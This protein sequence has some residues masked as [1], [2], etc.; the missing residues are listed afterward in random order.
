MKTTAR[1]RPAAKKEKTRLGA[2]RNKHPRVPRADRWTWHR[3]ALLHLRDR[4]MEEAREL[5]SANSGPLNPEVADFAEMAAGRSG[6]ELIEAELR[7]EEGLLEEVAAALGRIAA[8]TYGICEATGRPILPA[9]LRAIP[10]TRF[11]R[12]AAAEREVG[13]SRR[14]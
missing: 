3:L 11:N 13:R 1:R 6:R 7:T 8:G 4:L 5:K 10:W 9:R 12:V 14:R 2:A